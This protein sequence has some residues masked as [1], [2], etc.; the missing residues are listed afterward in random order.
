MAGAGFKTRR[1]CMGRTAGRAT[2]KNFCGTTARPNFILALP[3]HQT[4]AEATERK[5]K[6]ILPPLVK[7]IHVV[8]WPEG[9]KDANDFFLSR[10]ADE[11]EKQCL[12]PLKT[13]AAAKD[14][15]T[16]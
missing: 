6:E 7:Q 15:V 11:F 1:R 16:E 3:N 14:E 9:V 5:G 10:S 2:M 12:E 4:G 8:K 13:G